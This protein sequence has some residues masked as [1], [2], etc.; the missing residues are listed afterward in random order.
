[1]RCGTGGIGTARVD[2]A[3][4]VVADLRQ[5]VLRRLALKIRWKG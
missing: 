1:L 5:R 3:V 2:D 4:E